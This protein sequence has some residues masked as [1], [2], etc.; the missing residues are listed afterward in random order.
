MIDFDKIYPE[1]L[2]FISTYDYPT[3][4]PGYIK[5]CVVLK[6][7]NKGTLDQDEINKF[8]TLFK[9]TDSRGRYQSYFDPTHDLRVG[10][11][12]PITYL[13]NSMARYYFNSSDMR[14]RYFC[15]FN[16]HEN[17]FFDNDRLPSHC[18]LYRVESLNAP[19]PLYE[20]IKNKIIGTRKKRT[21]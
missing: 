19:G 10:Q 16:T 17:N 18:A 14:A 8:E 3:D 15:A 9:L 7:I 13:T 2:Y 20:S 1:Y 6:R 4:K 12:L 21:E 5:K 11:Y